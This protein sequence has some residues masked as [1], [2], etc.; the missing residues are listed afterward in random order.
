M[1]NIFTPRGQESDWLG[2]GIVCL[3]FGLVWSGFIIWILFTGQGGP[4]TL[5]FF[6]VGGIFLLFGPAIVSVGVWACWRSIKEN[7]IVKNRMQTTATL[8][9]IEEWGSR[10]KSTS[11]TTG[12][13]E[14]E[15]KW[16]H[17]GSSTPVTDKLWVNMDIN[18]D[19]PKP[20]YTFQIYVDPEDEGAFVIEEK[21]VF[22]PPPEEFPLTSQQETVPSPEAEVA[23]PAPSSL[24][25]PS[26]PF[27]ERVRLKEAVP[28]QTDIPSIG[29]IVIGLVF[30][31]MGIFGILVWLEVIEPKNPS[32]R[33]S[34]WPFLIGYVFICAGGFLSVSSLLAYPKKKK[35]EE[36][37]ARRP[38][39][40][41]LWDY[42]WQPLGISAGHPKR[43]ELKKQLWGSILSIPLFGFLT[44]MAFTD[45]KGWSIPL[46]CLFDVLLVHAYISAYIKLRQ[47]SV[48]GESRLRFGAFPFYL[49]WP[50][51]LTLMKLPEGIRALE[52]HLRHIE[53]V[54]ETSGSR[55]HQTTCQVCYE[56]YS[57]TRELKQDQLLGRDRLEINWDL[58]DEP[59]LTT[60]LDQHIPR[61]WQLEVIGDTPGVQYHRHFLLPVYAKCFPS[62]KSGP[63]KVKS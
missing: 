44:R 28:L 10:R 56:L 59:D 27:R 39:Q 60:R 55:D 53:E 37:K 61:Y 3:I 54:S 14:I 50:M 36:G 47:F 40:P 2:A 22:S 4:P 35:M 17:P 41:W 23:S 31:G 25:Q 15:F 26:T 33:G 63:K 62:T 9:S 43:I 13:F 16:T 34:I 45:W 7:Q 1:A 18:P 8:L 58:P 20:G 19:I 48:R 24:E 30:I 5:T 11:G 6:I 52:L 32:S 57:E 42:D 12:H 51:R 38:N 21:P 49:G 29:L 46:L